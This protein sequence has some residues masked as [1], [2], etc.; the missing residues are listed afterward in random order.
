MNDLDNSSVEVTL[1][2]QHPSMRHQPPSSFDIGLPFFQKLQFQWSKWP[3]IYSLIP[4]K[5]PLIKST[6]QMLKTHLRYTVCWHTLLLS[7]GFYYIRLMILERAVVVWGNIVWFG[8]HFTTGHFNFTALVSILKRNIEHYRVW[9][10]FYHRHSTAIDHLSLDSIWYKREG[11]T[12]RD[13][14]RICN[15]GVSAWY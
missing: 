4:L 12:A 10:R 13:I 1:D 6:L 2:K 3:S 9:N 5:D 7:S 8:C 14:K 11:H 15:F